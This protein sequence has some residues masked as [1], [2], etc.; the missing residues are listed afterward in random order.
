MAVIFSDSLID[1]GGPELDAITPDV[2]TAFV[3]APLWATAGLLS[4]TGAYSDR[5]IT[6]YWSVYR[7]TDVFPD[8]QYAQC[9]INLNN[10]AAA[11]QSGVIVRAS[12]STVDMYGIWLRP[13]QPLPIQIYRYDAGTPSLLTGFLIPGGAAVTTY[14]LRAEVVTSGAQ[15]DVSVY[16]NDVLIGT[17]ADTSASRK[18]SGFAGVVMRADAADMELLNFE[19]GSLSELPALT[20]STEENRFFQ[21]SSST[22]GTAT[23]SGTYVGTPATIERNVDAGGWVTAVASPAGG[24]FSDSFSLAVGEHS[25]AYRFSDDTGV[26]DT[27][28][29]VAVG[30][31]FAAAGQSNMSGRGTN[32]QVF[33][34]S[35]GGL[36]GYLFGNDDNFKIL[37]DPHDSGTGQV[38]AISADEN[39]AGSWIVR[40]AHHW[41][42]S[43]EVPICIIPCSSGGTSIAQW[44]KDSTDRIAS[45][46]LF[47]SSA[48]RIAAVGGIESFLFEQG[49]RDSNLFTVNSVYQADLEQLANDVQ[50]DFGVNLFLIPLHTITAAGHDGNGTTTG[51]GPI[52]L[53]QIAAATANANIDISAAIDDIDISAGDGIHIIEDADLDTVASRA[54]DS[55]ASLGGSVVAVSAAFGQA[56][57]AG[58]AAAIA[59]TSLVSLTPEADF[60]QSH[61]YPSSISL[62]AQVDI[63]AGYSASQSSGYPASIV[64][65]SPVAVTAGYVSSVS[66]SYPATINLTSIVQVD[67]GYV[68]SI[69]QGYSATLALAGNIEVSAG[70]GL[71]SSSGYPAGILLSAPIMVPVGFLS[72][73]SA[74]YQA[75]IE[76]NATIEIQAGF[77]YSESLAYRPSILVGVTKRITSYT[78][79]YA[80]SPQTITYGS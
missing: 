37:V 10:A 66:T 13:N 38:D 12:S 62:T 23:I 47:E 72:S 43:N 11:N 75:S 40:F 18:T 34:N 51:Q 42:A 4:A 63:D 80:G 7:C 5:V 29:N 74:G 33:S 79:N 76:L 2:G 26:T 6:P 25:I 49:E 68:G 69:S 60:A 58:F 46:N 1:A 32:S 77:S 27:I 78:I 16:W 17:Y 52:R 54:Y 21:R 56:I 9:D 22:S 71:S 67:A 31:V 3:Q 28:A 61:G 24:V 70:Y 8:D 73:T 39:A 59:L 30:A 65:G 45:L 14:N 48:R 50:T 15:V 36:T 44:Q 35:A 53:A 55:F 41:L 64:I 57:S 19:A 20:I